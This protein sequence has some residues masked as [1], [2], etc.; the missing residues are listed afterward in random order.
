MTPDGAMYFEIP[1]LRL[2]FRTYFGSRTRE[3]PGVLASVML[4]PDTRR[5][6]LTWQ[7]SLPVTATQIDHLDQTIVEEARG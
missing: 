1:A 6:R 4:E 5:V 7:T 2:V 3:H